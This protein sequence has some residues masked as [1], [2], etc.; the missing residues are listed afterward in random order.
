MY[1]HLSVSSAHDALLK[2][3][4]DFIHLQMYCALARF[5]RI[6][7]DDFEGAMINHLASDPDELRSALRSHGASDA[8]IQEAMEIIGLENGPDTRLGGPSP[9]DWPEHKLSIWVERCVSDCAQDLI[10]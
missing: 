3:I 9:E 2:S 5:G 10:S 8:I 7:L 1:N 4:G 6:D